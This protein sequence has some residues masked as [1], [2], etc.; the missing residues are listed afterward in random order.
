MSAPSQ[1][2]LDV[3]QHALGVDRFGRGRQYRNHY[4]VGPGCDGYDACC[5][6]VDAGF[7]H[8]YRPSELSGGNYT[9]VVTDAGRR[10]VSEHS[11]SPPKYTRSQ[12]RYQQWLDADCGL[13]FGEWLRMR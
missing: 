3:L 10:A 8:R 4:V 6:N 13:R 9:F 12:K 7:M 11:P 2:Q 1:Q 5:A